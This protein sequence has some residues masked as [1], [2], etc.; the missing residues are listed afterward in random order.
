MKVAPSPVASVERVLVCAGE[1]FFVLPLFTCNLRRG[2][3][4]WVVS[5]WFLSFALVVLEMACA[6]VIDDME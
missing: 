4:L 2:I 5:F 6:P 3:M 1:G